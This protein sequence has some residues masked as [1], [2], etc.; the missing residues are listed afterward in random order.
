MIY[1]FYLLPIVMIVSAISQLRTG[2]D[3]QIIYTAGAAD[4]MNFTGHYELSI[5]SFNSSG[6]LKEARNLTQVEIFA[7]GY[8][9]VG[10]LHGTDVVFSAQLRDP[11][12]KTFTDVALYKLTMSDTPVTHLTPAILDAASAAA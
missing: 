11:V 7:M 1:L 3:I 5:A 9:T 10:G 12:T 2:S 4:M 6:A 8:L